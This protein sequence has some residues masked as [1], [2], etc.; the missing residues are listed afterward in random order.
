MKFNLIPASLTI[1]VQNP[2][3]EWKALVPKDTL[4][5]NRDKLSLYDQPSSSNKVRY[6]ME[7]RLPQFTTLNRLKDVPSFEPHGVSLK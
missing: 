4:S 7:L 5:N 1:F 2:N 3:R 6:F